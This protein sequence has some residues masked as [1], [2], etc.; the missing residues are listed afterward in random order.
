MLTKF[1]KYEDIYK[2]ATTTEAESILLQSTAEDKLQEHLQKRYGKIKEFEFLNYNPKKI[3]G[4][5]RKKEIMV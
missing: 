4:A 2:C 5:F 1:I 3:A